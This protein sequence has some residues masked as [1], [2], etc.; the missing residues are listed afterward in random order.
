MCGHLDATSTP[1]ASTP[2]P[3]DPPD[4][5]IYRIFLLVVPDS[6]P[7]AG[8]IPLVPP[9]VSRKYLTFILQEKYRLQLSAGE[10]WKKDAVF[11]LALLR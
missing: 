10:N 8:E 4:Y 9:S 7:S 3:P 1:P 5:V 6:G 2:R 11:S